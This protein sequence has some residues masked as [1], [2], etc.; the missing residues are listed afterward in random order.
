MI[1]NTKSVPGG[2]LT[3]AGIN[4]I[5]MNVSTL[6]PKKPEQ[7]AKALIEQFGGKAKEAAE[8]HMHKAMEAG[9]VKMAGDWLAVM[10]ELPKM[11]SVQMH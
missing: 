7:C 10:H 5:G 2:V 4:Y 6:N 9:D 11:A 3:L 8:G 1:R